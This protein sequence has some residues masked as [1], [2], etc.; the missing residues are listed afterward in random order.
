MD[1]LRHQLE[2]HSSGVFQQ[3]VDDN[4]NCKVNTEIFDNTLPSE[5]EFDDPTS[6]QSQS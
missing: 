1:L 6:P 3:E 4:D 5:L 2:T